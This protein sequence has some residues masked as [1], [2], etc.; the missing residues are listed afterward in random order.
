VSSWSPDYVT[1]DYVLGHDLTGLAWGTILDL[2]LLE[3]VGGC[4]D[5]GGSVF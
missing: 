5:T 1:P 3:R 4:G 2:Q